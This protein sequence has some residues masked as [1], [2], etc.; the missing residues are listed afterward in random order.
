MEDLH[1]NAHRRLVISI[2]NQ[3]TTTVERILGQLATDKHG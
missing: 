2:S 1:A 3:R